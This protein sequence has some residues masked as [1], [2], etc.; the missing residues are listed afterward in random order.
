[1]HASRQTLQLFLLACLLVA[2]V[3]VVEVRWGLNMGD[4]GYQYNGTLMTATG[5]M[6]I[7]D[8]Q[9]YDPGRYYWATPFFNFGGPTYFSLRLANAMFKVIGLFFGL[10]VLRRIYDRPGYL[11]LGAVC[12]LLWMEPRHKVFEH[13]WAMIL[14]YVATLVAEDPRPR[15]WLVAGLAVGLAAFF[16]RNIGAYG[17]L[18]M[19]ILAGILLWHRPPIRIVASGS[20]L[21]AGVMVGYSPMGVLTVINPEFLPELIRSATD[22][23]AQGS[24]SASLPVPWPWR[25]AGWQRGL[26]GVMFLALPLTFGAVLAW[27]VIRRNLRLQPLAPLAGAACV[28]IIFQNQAFA[29]ADFPH[30]AQAIHPLLL[31]VLALPLLLREEYRG[32]VRQTSLAIILVVTCLAVVPRTASYQ[33]FVGPAFEPIQIAGGELMLAPYWTKKLAA[34]KSFSE[35]CMGPEDTIYINA[36]FQTL[37]SVIAKQPPVWEIGTWLARPMFY[38][39]KMVRQLEENNVW[40]AVLPDVALDGIEERHFRNTHPLVWSYFENHFVRIKKG[41]ILDGFS[42]WRRRDA[43]GRVGVESARL[44]IACH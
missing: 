32:A 3:F 35:I 41:A 18:G 17:G 1:M 27:L 21:V 29:R 24:S 14:V 36:G 23:L 22:Q 33:R 20:A 37:Y 13:S 30:L 40:W 34:F 8:F 15:R 9:S 44:P 31:T 25:V 2:A 42:I 26:T 5:L 6:P 39:R 10:L 11:V 19:L 28:G 7:A 16:G 12:L 38:Q 43:G 4:E